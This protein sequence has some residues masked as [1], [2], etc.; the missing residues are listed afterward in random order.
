[1]SRKVRAGDPA[2]SIDRGYLVIGIKG[3]VHQAG[4]VAWA[5]HTGRWPRA[6]VDHIN[7]DG[8]DNRLINL[9]LSTPAENGRNSKRYSTN[10]SGYKGVKPSK[11]GKF[12]AAICINRRIVYL[13]KH[14]T[15]QDA[16]AA[17][18][19]AA[20]KYHGEFASDGATPMRSS[21]ALRSE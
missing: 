4:R 12:E 18:C 8:L 17:Y 9:R 1:M 10:S 11:D 6:F 5:L 14:P 13:G 21:R 19:E 15:P 20:R 16:H 3:H 7:G 2:G